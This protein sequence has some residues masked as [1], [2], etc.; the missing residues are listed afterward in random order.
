MYSAM[1]A[2]EFSAEISPSVTRPGIAV[3]QRAQLFDEGQVLRTRVVIHVVLVGIGVVGAKA[4]T[5]AL[6]R[7]L[8]RVVAQLPIVETEVDGIEAHA[9]HAT[10]Q[11]EA[12]V[13]EHGAP[14]RLAVE[15]EIRLL[16]QEIVQVVLR[17]ARLPLPG[18]TAEYRQPVVGRAAIGAGI[19]PHVPVGARIVATLPAFPEPLVFSRGV[20][21]HLV[22]H[23]LQAQRVGLGQQPVEIGQRAEQR[24]D[25]A[26]VGDVVAE[27]GHRRFEERRDPH[28]LDAQARH[29]VEPLDDP[30]Q[31][32]DAIAIGIEEAAWIDLV[33]HRAM[34]PGVRRRQRRPSRF[35]DRYVLAQ[36]RP[37]ISSS[38]K[39][40]RCSAPP[41]ANAYVFIRRAAP[42]AS[43]FGTRRRSP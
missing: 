15:V 40:T 29:I 13:V 24:V 32:A 10:L 34:P 41:V 21:Q 26:V 23:D 22:D 8:G 39:L 9:I 20:A 35:F 18:A 42:P 38:G 4:A 1:V 5:A 33:D 16:G 11:P 27:V 43:M 17:A 12:H 37:L 31:V 6:L 30:R 14:H 28:G 2:L 36:G 19:G 25:R 3:D 7:G